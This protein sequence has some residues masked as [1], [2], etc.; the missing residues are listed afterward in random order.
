MGAEPIPPVV[1]S[2]GLVH[3]FMRKFDP[4]TDL[5]DAIDHCIRAADIVQSSHDNESVLD[6]TTACS[7]AMH[8]IQRALEMQLEAAVNEDYDMK[9]LK[10]SSDL[11]YCMYDYIANN[12]GMTRSGVDNMSLLQSL[13]V[14]MR[15]VV[16][17]MRLSKTEAVLSDAECG[18]GER[19]PVYDMFSME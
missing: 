13:I 5:E 12:A 11:L 10:K 16:S 1:H 18:F 2:K 17:G 9:Y 4:L 15:D 3:K 19:F 7:V 8:Y 6:Y 14:A